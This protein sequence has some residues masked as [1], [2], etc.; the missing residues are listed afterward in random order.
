MSISEG[1]S[2]TFPYPVPTDERGED[3]CIVMEQ[4]KRHGTVV[5]VGGPA[6]LIRPSTPPV[7]KMEETMIGGDGAPVKHER[8]V[9]HVDTL[10]K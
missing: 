7:F 1:D 6:A 9:R 8:V 3:Y 5:A 2:V 10:Q 4:E